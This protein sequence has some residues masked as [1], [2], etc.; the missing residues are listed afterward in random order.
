MC[1]H[2]IAMISEFANI[3]EIFWQKT[4]GD[5]G[6]KENKYTIKNALNIIVVS[7]NL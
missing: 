4:F 2:G 5:I 7:H 1:H 6:P 3:T